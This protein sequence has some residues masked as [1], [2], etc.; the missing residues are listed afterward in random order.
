MGRTQVWASSHENSLFLL[1][2]EDK[3]IGGYTSMSHSVCFNIS[4]LPII[5]F[6]K[7]IPNIDMSTSSIL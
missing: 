4:V 5:I 7:T 2:I 1:I 3:N 6:Y